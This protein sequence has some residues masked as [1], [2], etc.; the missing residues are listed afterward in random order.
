M[1]HAIDR[2]DAKPFE[3]PSETTGWHTAF[4]YFAEHVRTLSRGHVNHKILYSYVG[5]SGHYVNHDNPSI[6]KRTAAMLSRLIHSQRYAED[7]RASFERNPQVFDEAARQ[8]RVDLVE[9]AGYEPHA[10]NGYFAHEVWGDVERGLANEREDGRSDLNLARIASEMRLLFHW[11]N[12]QPRERAAD[13]FAVLVSSYFHLMAHGHLDE[14]LVYELADETPIRLSSGA[15]ERGAV[16]SAM[17]YD[18]AQASFACLVRYNDGDAG[19]VAGWRAVNPAAPFY[20][21]RY[22]D[23][24]II[25]TNPHVSRQHCRIGCRE[26]RWYLEDLG[27]RHGTC[28]L[29]NGAAVYDSARDDGTACELAFGDRIVL[30]GS[31]HYWFGSLRGHDYPSSW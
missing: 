4:Y 26:G 23:C 28:V 5:M 24:D 19:S 16:G 27:S 1:P 13:C 12:A 15:G 21:G 11:C 18:G 14:R 10:L 25:E 8:L 7:F 30:A 6:R 22:T 9:K 2:N 29:R 20:I 31:S 17:E 3:K